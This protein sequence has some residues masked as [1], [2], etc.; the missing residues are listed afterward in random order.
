VRGPAGPA[1]HRIT[2]SVTKTITGTLVGIAIDQEL[3]AGVQE[4]VLPFFAERQPAAHADPRKDEITVAD[5]LTMS[6]AWQ[7]NDDDPSSPGNEELMYDAADWTQFALDLPVDR[8]CPA[9]PARRFAAAVI[10][11]TNYNTR[12]MHQQ[13]ERLLAEYIPP[14]LA[15]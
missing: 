1:A 5:L 14:A 11:S 3:I 8:A 6:S 9:R 2:R 15:G 13:T 4:R 10:T 12:G 7:C